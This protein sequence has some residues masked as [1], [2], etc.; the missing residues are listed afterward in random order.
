VKVAL[1]GDGG[2]EAFG[3][4]SR[5]AG[6][7]RESALR[8]FVPAAM[9]RYALSPVAKRW[10]QADWLP[11]PMRAKTLLT[12]LSLQPGAAYANT[13]ALCRLPLRRQLLAPDLAAALNGSDPGFGI[14]ASYA[15]AAHQGPVAAMIASDIAVRLPDDYLVKVD[16]TS[17]AC[18]LEVRPP[19]LDHELLELSAR[20][21]P[22]LKV[23]NGTT[24]WIL[25]QSYADR[26]PAGISDRPKQGFDIPIDAWFRGPLREMFEST[27]LS[28]HS[29]VT[30]LLDVPTMRRVFNA[31]V[32]GRARNGQV[33]WTLL[34]FA[35]WGRLYLSADRAA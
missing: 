16:R 24:K 35:Q 17:M 27:M 20:I 3:G 9:Q 25:K 6:D 8:R 19:F 29:P 12:N 28:S 18:G 15:A 32:A 22:A 7:E 1:S 31:H 23:H 2:D 10:P 34:M 26:L 14:A 33:M 11:R 5:Y 13:L 30:E 4:Y 21:P